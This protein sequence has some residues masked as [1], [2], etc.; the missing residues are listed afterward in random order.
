MTTPHTRTK[1]VTAVVGAVIATIAAPALLVLGAGTA[2]A[3]PDISAH[4][5]GRHHRRSTHPAQL[6]WLRRIYSAARSARLSRTSSAADRRSRQHGRDHHRRECAVTVDESRRHD[7]VHH[8]RL[9]PSRTRLKCSAVAG[10]TQLGPTRLT[11]SDAEP[12]GS[13]RR[14][15]RPRPLAQTSGQ[16]SP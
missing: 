5:P 15:R 6:W 7:G 2:Q 11:E 9:I 12:A 13:G 1:L 16:I 4:G 8:L 14:A 10:A 3:T